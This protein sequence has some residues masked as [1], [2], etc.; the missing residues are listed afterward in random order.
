MLHPPTPRTIDVDDAVE[1]LRAHD[2]YG[3]LTDEAALRRFLAAHVFCVWDFQ[4]LLKALQREVTCVEPLW[5]PT[6]DPEA[7]RLVNEI[8]LEEESD[9]MTDGSHLS[10]YEMY[11]VAMRAAGA[12]E[13]PI[14]G[15]HRALERGATIDEALARADLPPGVGAFVRATLDVALSGDAA[16]IAGAFTYGREEAIP[17]MFGELVARLAQHDPARWEPFRD[18]LERHIECD[19][20][21]HG[22]QARALVAR[23]CGDDEALW[24]RAETAARAALAA[25]IALWDAL[26]ETVAG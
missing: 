19:A 4:C 18:Y 16:R 11:R 9:R 1:A 12:D 22:P 14:D 6:P 3:R 21:K 7:R 15:F 5:M 20:E 24:S 13:G 8:V 25:R 17:R 26:A 23:L 2:L 10:H